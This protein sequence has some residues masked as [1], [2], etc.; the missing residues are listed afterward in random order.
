MSVVRGSQRL[1]KPGCKS[2]ERNRRLM[3][4]TEF[5][6]AV[7][8]Q[9]TYVER[10]AGAAES[11][12]FYLYSP[13]ESFYRLRDIT[14]GLDQVLA[15]QVT[16]LNKSK[17]WYGWEQV[18]DGAEQRTRQIVDAITRKVIDRFRQIHIPAAANRDSLLNTYRNRGMTEVP[19]F[20]GKNEEEVQLG[21]FNQLITPTPIALGAVAE[22][23]ILAE[24]EKIGGLAFRRNQLRDARALLTEDRAR[25]QLGPLTLLYMQAIDSALLPSF[26]Q[27]KINAD[28]YLNQQ[29]VEI[30]KNR[31]AYY[32]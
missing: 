14:H 24:I 16:C 32:D 28:I 29:E 11:G 3:P 22:P 30:K 27:Y 10:E 23:T 7:A 12:P 17:K 8:P 21:I 6:G 18:A 31:K 1:L 20:A 19:A 4:E 15:G 25:A 26:E 2:S 9:V 5:I 13:A